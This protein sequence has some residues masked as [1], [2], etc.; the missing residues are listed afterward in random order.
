MSS[1]FSATCFTLKFFSLPL[2]W[3]GMISMTL[4]NENSLSVK[5]N[6]IT[7]NFCLHI[8]TQVNTFFREQNGS[9]YMK[10]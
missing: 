9:N 5:E 3:K 8:E 7:V 6:K 2:L 10:L 4:H 1:A